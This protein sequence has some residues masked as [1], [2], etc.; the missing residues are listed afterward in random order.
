MY[1]KY[2]EYF[3]Q[4][5]NIQDARYKEATKLSEQ[6]HNFLIKN[7]A[8]LPEGRTFD[9]IIAE[10]CTPLIQTRLKESQKLFLH[11]DKYLDEFDVR[12]HEYCKNIL[13]F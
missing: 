4:Y 1:E 2:K 12:M 9:M 6:V 5:V 10:E 11:V 3:Q 7:D 13:S 8:N